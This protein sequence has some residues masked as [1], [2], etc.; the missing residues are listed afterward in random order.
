MKLAIVGTG[1]MGKVLRQYALEEGTFD[2]IFFIEPTEEN[3]WPSEKPDLLIDFSNP[4]AINSIYDF[5]RKKGGGFPV[6][7]ATT[8]YG[9]QEWEIIKLIQKICPMVQKNNFSRGVEVMNRLAEQGAQLL[10]DWA[11]IRVMEAHHTKKNDA[12]SG[13]ALMLA[14]GIREVRPDSVITTGRSGQG[15]RE[16]NEIGIQSVRLGN[17]VGIHEIMISTGNET[18]TIKH[19]ASDRALFADGA[20]IAAEFLVGKPAALY[21]MSDITQQEEEA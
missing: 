7:L 19:E 5:C 3:T 2:T 14:E 18:I 8:G 16:A 9:P 17:V 6:V 11:D 1:A 4:G 15:K 20:V 13:T 10:G 21:N 12:P